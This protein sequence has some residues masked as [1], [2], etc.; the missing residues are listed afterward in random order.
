M[1]RKKGEKIYKNKLVI[2]FKKFYV[3]A[4]RAISIGFECVFFSFA[5]FV[6][7]IFNVNTRYT[8]Q[9]TAK[10]IVSIRLT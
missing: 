2:V 8:Q 9:T 4:M 10:L 6:P 5:I 7:A 1:K 3:H